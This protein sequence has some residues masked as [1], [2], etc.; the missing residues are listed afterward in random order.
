MDQTCKDKTAL[1]RKFG[2][3]H[4]EVM[5]LGLKKSGATFQRMMDN[6]L[7]NVRVIISFSAYIFLENIPKI[8]EPKVI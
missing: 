4:F 8:P 2:T 3:N 5:P 6:T 7:V 1:I